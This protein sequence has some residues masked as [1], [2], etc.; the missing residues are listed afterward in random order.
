[1]STFFIT[2]PHSFPALQA[3]IHLPEVI[4]QIPDRQQPFIDGLTGPID[5]GSASRCGSLPMT[6]TF[7]TTSA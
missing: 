4:N 6:S 7:S 2:D 1:M 5:A 3:V